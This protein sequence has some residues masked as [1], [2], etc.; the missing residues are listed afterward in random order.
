MTVAEPTPDT[1]W[2]VADIGG[3]YARFGLI[4]ALDAEPHE[5]RI[6]SCAD[7][8]D[9]VAAATD[10][11]TRVLGTSHPVAACVADPDHRRR[12]AHHCAG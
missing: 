2:L 3:T 1:P 5:V 11:L 9:L 8:P 4:P 6:L 12:R 10:Y 7:Y